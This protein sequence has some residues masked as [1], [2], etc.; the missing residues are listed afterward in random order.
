MLGVKAKLLERY[1]SNMQLKAQTNG[2]KFLD[3]PKIIH[4]TF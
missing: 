1:F 3:F 4:L 2:Q